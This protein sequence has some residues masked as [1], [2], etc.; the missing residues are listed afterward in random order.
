MRKILAL[1]V[2]SLAV[3]AGAT[4]PAHAEDPVLP[5]SEQA[6]ATNA[7][8]PA[9]ASGYRFWTGNLCVQPGSGTS[10]YPIGYQAQQWNLRVGNTAVLGINIEPSCS[11]AGYP[12]SRSF[13][14][15][16]YSAPSQASC[17]AYLNTE[18]QYYNGM[19]R[20]TNHPVILINYGRAGCTNTTS[21]LYH[22]TGA[23]IGAALG[24]QVVNWPNS[25][26]RVMNSQPW[27]W[28]NVLYPTSTEGQR[29]WSIYTGAYGG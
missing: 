22:A 9:D 2:A 14:I 25:L 6:H 10:G 4:A 17:L 11:A 19:W 1:L 29:V 8:L 12:P 23:A 24:M 5:Y 13:T 20:W 18:A 15:G 3:L 7:A 26:N 27:S 21:R 16:V 28:D